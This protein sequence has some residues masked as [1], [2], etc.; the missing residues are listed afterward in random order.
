M[1]SRRG[2]GGQLGVR[3]SVEGPG[4]SHTCLAPRQQ[5]GVQGQGNVLWISSRLLPLRVQL[6][7]HIKQKSSAF[8]LSPL[9]LSPLL[10]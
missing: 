8:G 4:G 6:F 1:E 9:S 3:G 2:L 7:V 10:S 5:I